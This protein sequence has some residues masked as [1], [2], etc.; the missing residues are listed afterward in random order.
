VLVTIDDGF[1]SVHTEALPIL[2][3]YSIPVLR[4]NSIAVPEHS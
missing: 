1:A 2:C 4:K 3:N